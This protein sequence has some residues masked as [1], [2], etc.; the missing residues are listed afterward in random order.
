MNNPAWSN[1]FS[2]QAFQGEAAECRQQAILFGQL[3]GEGEQDWNTGLAWR[4]EKE[5]VKMHRGIVYS[6]TSIG[7]YGVPMPK[8]RGQ[9]GW[10]LADS[11]ISCD[12]KR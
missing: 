2:L 1:W 10:I 5:S 7:D 12:R 4:S 3:M 9:V 11:V 8:C 6:R